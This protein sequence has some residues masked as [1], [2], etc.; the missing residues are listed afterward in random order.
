MASVMAHD[1]SQE[2]VSK[3]STVYMCSLDVQ[4]AFDEI[5][6]SVL[7][8]KTM[9]IIPDLPWRVLCYWYGN[10]VARIKWNKMV[11]QSFCIGR[12]TKQRGLSSPMI[13][14]IVYQDLVVTLNSMNCGISIEKENY[15]VFA[16]ADDLLVCSL[17][18]TGLQKLIDTAS[19]NVEQHGLKF[20]SGKTKCMVY[21][22]HP[23]NQ[24]P[25]WNIAGEQLTNTESLTYL[26]CVLDGNKPGKGSSHVQNRIRTS[27]RAFLSL[28][29]VGLRK[30]GVSPCTALNIYQTT[31][32]S[33]LSYGC[34]SISISDQNMKLMDKQQAKQIKC[35]LGLNPYQTKTTPLLQALGISLISESTNIHSLDL[36]RQ[37]LLSESNTKRFFCYMMTQSSFNNNTLVGRVKKFA[38]DKNINLLQYVFN[39]SYRSHVKK[40]IFKE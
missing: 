28:E 14:N 12:G 35:M 13:F 30:N 26:G 7:L 1:V 21:G 2:C 24:T 6:H 40:S 38:V 16:Y 3:G 29:S 8:H 34:T 15:N 32:R 11:G 5:P 22:K 39:D 23:F 4:G 20:N 25:S 9:G 10:M 33:T 36:L 19:V 17:S 18:V 27:Q 31:V 37:C